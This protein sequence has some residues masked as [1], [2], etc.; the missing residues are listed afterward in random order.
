[1]I[2]EIQPRFIPDMSRY[3]SLL[4]SDDGCPINDVNFVKNERAE[5]A[6][7]MGQNVSLNEDF[8]PPLEEV[9]EDT[10][11]NSWIPKG[12]QSPDEFMTYIDELNK[13]NHDKT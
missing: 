13:F 1:M 7:I 3:N 11:F 8:E 2:D 6:T 4:V 10:V 5:V 9:S 12:V